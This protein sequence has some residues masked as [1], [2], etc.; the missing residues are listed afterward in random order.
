MVYDRIVHL[1]TF[2]HHKK[3]V[4]AGLTHAPSPLFFQIVESGNINNGHQ[5]LCTI[6]S[7]SLHFLWGTTCLMF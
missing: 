7:L 2:F 6:P 3:N 5:E 4:G 1:A